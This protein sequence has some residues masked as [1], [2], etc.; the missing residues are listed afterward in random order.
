[1]AKRIS[2]NSY[3][4]QRQYILEDLQTYTNNQLIQMIAYQVGCKEC[5]AYST[6]GKSDRPTQPANCV[7]ELVHHYKYIGR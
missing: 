1:M 5:P 6:C 4:E 2:Y 3:H 7:T